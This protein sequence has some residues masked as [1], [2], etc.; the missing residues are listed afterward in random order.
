MPGLDQKR[1]KYGAVRTEV[2]GLKFASKR[3]AKRYQELRLL[4]KAGE[5][6]GLKCQHPYDLFAPMLFRPVG[7]PNAFDRHPV[8]IGRYVADFIYYDRQGTF[9][10]EDVKGFRTPLYQ[11]KKRH[12]EAQYGVTITEV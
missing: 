3:E 11:W 10:V 9:H 4:E 8:K 5:I 6:K 2:D 12:V 1:H 7:H